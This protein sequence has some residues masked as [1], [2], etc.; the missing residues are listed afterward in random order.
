MFNRVILMG[1][2]TK[3]PEVRTTP[4][5]TTLCKFSIAVNR[6]FA[7]QGEER[8]ADF[9]NITAWG[10]TAE[11]VGKWFS[12]GRMIF[13][14]G[15]IENDNYT[16]NNNVKHYS[17]NIIAENVSFCGNKS[18]NGGGNGYPNNGGGYGNNGYPN[19]GGGYGNNG[20]PNNGGGY[21]NNGYPNNGGGYGNNGY[22]NNGGG[23]GNN[24]Y[25]NNGGNY[26]NNGY[27]GN[28][29]YPN[30]FTP[31][32]PAPQP[33][34]AQQS[35]PQAPPTQDFQT[36]PP[37]TDDKKTVELGDISDFQEIISDGDVPF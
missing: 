21:G 26:G 20:Y 12:R 6:R 36:A 8:Q 28:G 11:F 15:R 30:N 14:E 22:P 35:A 24:G 16:D 33:A 7:K 19:N 10:Q 37:N 23:Y 5:G 2:L 34:P 18:D 1:N 3:D 32:Q 9:F 25:P 27:G 31:Q 13:V 4:S 17:M 29:G